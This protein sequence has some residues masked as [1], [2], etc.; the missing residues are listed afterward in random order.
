MTTPALLVAPAISPGTLATINQRL[1]ATGKQVVEACGLHVC[2]S[3]N[4]C[5]A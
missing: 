3:L 2:G 5:L 1:D 4:G